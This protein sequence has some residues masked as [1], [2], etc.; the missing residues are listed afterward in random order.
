MKIAIGKLGKA[1]ASNLVL[2]ASLFAGMS[3][4]AA[5]NFCNV[6]GQYTGAYVGNTDQG[7]LIVSVDPVDGTLR[8]TAKSVAGVSFPFG[9]VVSS[10]GRF[11][12]SLGVVASGAQFAGSFSPA[13]SGAMQ[14]R[15]KWAT[16]DGQ[17]GD[18]Q[19][20]REATPTNCF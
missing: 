3:A 11:S 9:G 4:Q 17:G 15:G 12:S 18:W 16:A 19:I 6:A 13:G 8:G 1:G 2:L 10:T 5:S 14:G 20:V 7:T